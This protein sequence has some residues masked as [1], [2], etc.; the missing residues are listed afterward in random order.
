MCAKL[1]SSLRMRHITF[2]F[3]WGFATLRMRLIDDASVGLNKFTSLG[4]R[5]YFNAPP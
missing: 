1:F 5:F 4:I 2:N 3:T